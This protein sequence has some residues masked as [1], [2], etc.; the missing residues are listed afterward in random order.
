[1]SKHSLWAMK[2]DLGLDAEQATARVARDLK[3]TD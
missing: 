3:A 2:R 1:M